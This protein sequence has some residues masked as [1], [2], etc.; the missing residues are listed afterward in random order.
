ML[1]KLRFIT[2]SF[3]RIGEFLIETTK[4]F[5]YILLMFKTVLVYVFCHSLA[6]EG[7]RVY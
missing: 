6:C 7:R 1:F 2:L 3:V 5:R 4:N